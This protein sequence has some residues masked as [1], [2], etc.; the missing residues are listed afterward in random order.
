MKEEKFMIH[1]HRTGTDGE[2]I[3]L[4]NKNGMDIRNSN[5]WERKVFFMAWKTFSS[6]CLMVFNICL[7]RSSACGSLYKYYMRNGVEKRVEESEVE[8]L[9][10][11]SFY[12]CLSIMA[13][14]VGILC[15]FFWQSAARTSA[16]TTTTA[17]LQIGLEK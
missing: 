2:C 9:R 11:N 17:A 5:G 10:Q 12:A 3:M 1:V 4:S 8:N 6:L 14:V 7:A 15:S 13:F 16:S